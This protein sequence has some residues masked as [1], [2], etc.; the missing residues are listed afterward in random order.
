M[1]GF[2]DKP[3]F[4]AIV[5]IL[6]IIYWFSMRW[7]WMHG[8][9]LQTLFA[10]DLTLI[11]AA[12]IQSDSDKVW[13]DD[14]V[15]QL[16]VTFMCTHFLYNIMHITYYVVSLFFVLICFGPIHNTII[17]AVQNFAQSNLHFDM[18]RN[19]VIAILILFCVLIALF[20]VFMHMKRVN[21]LVFISIRSV[22]GAFIVTLAVSTLRISFPSISNLFVCLFTW[23]WDDLQHTHFNCERGLTLV[24]TPQPEDDGKCPLYFDVYQWIL[25]GVTIVVLGRLM[26]KAEIS[27]VHVPLD[28]QKQ[29]K[30]QEEEAKKQKN[31]DPIYTEADKKLDKEET[32]E[33]T[34]ISS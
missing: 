14:F 12:I 29:Q 6:N 9:W 4:Y 18:T 1:P 10:F 24:D 13:P 15:G 5:S 19:E 21:K 32:V 20:A 2:D 34:S 28:K 8:R 16:V 23:S 17:K 25:F 11:I 30:L 3:H 27:W 33:L 22:I 7:R 26:W 31:T